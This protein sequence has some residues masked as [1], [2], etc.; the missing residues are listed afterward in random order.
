MLYKSEFELESKMEVD[1]L[2]WVTPATDGSYAF[3]SP[4]VLDTTNE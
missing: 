3:P 2:P 4:V 1:V